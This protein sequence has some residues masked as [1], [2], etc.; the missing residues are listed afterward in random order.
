MRLLVT[1]PEPDDERTAL[2]L[3]GRRHDVLRAP[4]LRVESLPEV[5]LG[6]GPFDAVLMTSVQAARAIATHPRRDELLMLPVYAVGQRTAE[7]AREAGFGE[8][9]SAEGDGRDLGRLLASRPIQTTG[10]LLY[11]AGEDRARNLEKE[12]A[13]HALTLQVAVIYRAV[14]A[15]ELGAPTRQALE[16]GRL[17]GVLHFSARSAAVFLACARRAGLLNQAVKLVHY[18]LSRQ[19]A[20]P[21]TAAGAVRIK[22]AARPEEAALLDLI[23]PA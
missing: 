5:D 20:A 6:D 13:G 12:L 9:T 3:S 4:L 22:V 10:R 15:E 14:A 23:G 18:C 8:V 7:A 19:V 2:A 1:R 11:L 17:E 21:L 16:S